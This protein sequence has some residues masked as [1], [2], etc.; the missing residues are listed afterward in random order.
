VTA[1]ELKAILA[2]DPAY[3]KMRAEKDAALQE[4]RRILVDDASPL[5]EDLRLAGWDVKTA[6]DLVNTA[7]PYPS[8]IPVLLRHLG[9][10]YLDR[11][12]EGIARALAVR[13]AAYAWPI[14]KAAYELAPVDSGAKSGLAVA[15][16]ATASDE[17]ITELAIL[18]KDRAN[19]SSRLLLLDGLRRSRSSVARDALTELADDPDLAKEIA[20]WKSRKTNR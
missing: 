2:T 10:P 14:L 6:W 3:Q 12:R 4:R 5:A 13:D 1:A 18:A 15:L 7:T 11:N 19:G 17:T 8:A 16:S 20:S 9:E